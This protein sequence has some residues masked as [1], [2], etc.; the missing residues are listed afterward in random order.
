MVLLCRVPWLPHTT[1]RADID[2]C[3]GDTINMALNFSP[4]TRQLPVLLATT[5]S[6]LPILL[7]LITCL[8]SLLLAAHY[9]RKDYHAFLALGP[10]G[11]PSTPTGYARI[12]ILR[13]F[14]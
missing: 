11:T 9:I 13:L 10:G 3:G 5:N 4:D 8:P 1:Q 14:T 7:L 12:C 6:P 2:R